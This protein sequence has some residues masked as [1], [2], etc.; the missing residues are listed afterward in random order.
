MAFVDKRGVLVNIILVFVLV[1]ALCVLI[2]Y[3]VLEF[4]FGLLMALVVFVLVINW[5]M[6]SLAYMKFRRV[7]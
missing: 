6:I 4:V 3:F 1:T 2:N 7:K 5:A